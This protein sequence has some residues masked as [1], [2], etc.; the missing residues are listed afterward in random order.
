MLLFKRRACVLRCGRVNVISAVK[1]LL[2]PL[3]VHFVGS[4]FVRNTNFPK[5]INVQICQ[6][7]VW[8]KASIMFKAP[9]PKINL[10][11]LSQNSIFALLQCNTNYFS[12]RDNNRWIVDSEIPVLAAISLILIPSS[13][14]LLQ[15]KFAVENFFREP[16]RPRSESHQVPRPIRMY[17]NLATLLYRQS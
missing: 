10:I 17:I 7:R 9:S 14:I 11:F 12:G 5:I 2:Y 16:I 6:A 4:G 13:F 8:N 3:V 15:R 1:T